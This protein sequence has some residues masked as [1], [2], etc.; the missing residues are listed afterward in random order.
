MQE[1]ASSILVVDDQPDNID[2]IRDILAD[3]K[4]RIF[5]ASNGKEAIEFLERETPDLILLDALMPVMD[6]FETARVIKS[7]PQTKLIPIIMI[8]ALDSPQ[9]RV[10]GLESG[11]DDFI[12][13]PF[14]IFE[15]KARINNLLR[16]RESLNELE[17]A[18]QVI[19]SLAR[20]VEAK[21][22]YT[23]GHCNRLANLAE[24]MG[25]FLQLPEYE[26]KILKRGGILHDIGKIAIRDSILLKPGKLTYEE[27][28]IIKKHP[29]IGVEICS[30]LKTLRP[31]LPVILYHHERFD[32]SGYPE[33]L[34]GHDIPL[35][36]RIVG[37]VDCFDSI[38]TKRPYRQ[39][40]SYSD[41]L[42]FCEQE[43]RRGLWDPELFKAFKSLVSHPKF[44][45]QTY[46]LE[47]G[48][49]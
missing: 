7:N 13:R 32:G 14:N 45:W 3:P 42:E 31:V 25:K 15:L 46:V 48:H 12:S 33:G 39:P 17:N 29:Q 43:M 27:F 10:K 8:T 40:L 4:Y 1:E 19:F 26:L 30:P 34:K 6:G 49:S 11:V 22:R 20:A 24:S 36:A 35:H 38:T 21:D 37:L 18:E 9:D 41:A 23:E 16:L 5:S 47:D 44:N 28:E 2:T